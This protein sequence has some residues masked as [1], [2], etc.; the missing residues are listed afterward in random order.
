M[1][2]GGFLGVRERLGGLFDDDLPPTRATRIFHVALAVLI[3][4][5]VSGVILESVD[6]FNQRFGA[7]LW[8]LEQIATTIFAIEYVLRAWTCV[9]IHH[10]QFRHPLWGRLRYLRSF[11]ALIDLVSCRRSSACSAPAICARSGYC[12][13]CAC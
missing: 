12:A 11:F 3:F 2:K 5:N 13:C 10:G 1:R 4:V 8:W 6:S 7:V 9:E